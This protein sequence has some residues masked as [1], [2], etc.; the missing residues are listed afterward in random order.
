MPDLRRSKSFSGD[1]PLT[2]SIFHA[3][4]FLPAILYEGM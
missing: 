1:L 2:R 4:F 3:T